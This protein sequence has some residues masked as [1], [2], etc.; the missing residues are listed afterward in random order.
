MSRIQVQNDQLA[1]GFCPSDYQ[2]LLN[3]FSQAQYVDLS[4][5]ESN[6]IV[7]AT[8]PSDTTKAWLQLDQFGRP[9]RIYWFAQGAWLSMHPQPAGF[10]MPWFDA[11]P[12]FSTF[13]G[14]DANASSAISGPMWERITTLDGRFPLTA[15]TLP[16][17]TIVAQG[18]VGGEEKHVLTVPELPAH[19]HTADSGFTTGDDDGAGERLTSGQNTG[20]DRPAVNIVVDNT[21]DDEGHNNMPPYVGMA[22]LRRTSRLFYTVP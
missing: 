19:T 17:G 5:E 11:L 12:N 4:S 16:S 14:G 21:G 3:T 20:N 7:S 22:W 6:L 1:A 18:G 10:V 2:D 8:K 15:G 13:D 9:V